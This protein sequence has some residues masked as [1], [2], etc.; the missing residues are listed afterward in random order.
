MKKEE[1]FCDRFPETK[2][3]R[4]SDDPPCYGDGPALVRVV[5]ERWRGKISANFLY[6][7]IAF[8]ASGI[9]PRFVVVPTGETKTALLRPRYSHGLQLESASSSY[10]ASH[11]ARLCSTASRF[12]LA[13]S[14][15]SESLFASYGISKRFT[16]ARFESRYCCN[17]LYDRLRK[18]SEF[19][20]RGDSNPY[21]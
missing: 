16:K 19:C 13:T 9:F 7:E 10:A 11:C 20:S 12:C 1:F 2:L 8:S 4:S 14:C 6:H 17:W 18:R 5:E 21:T 15:G 3:C